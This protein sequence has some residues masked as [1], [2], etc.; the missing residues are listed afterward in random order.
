MRKYIGLCGLFLLLTL[1][2]L[3]QDYPKAE[4]FGG[5]SY[6]RSGGANFNGGSGSVA[7]N[8][9]PWL[10]LLGDIGVYHN[11]QV[12]STNF[13]TYLFGPR[14]SYRKSSKITPYAQFVL[15]G[16]HVSSSFAGFSASANAFALSMGGGLEAGISPR[17][18]VRLVQAEYL[19]T[20]NSGGTGNSARI[21]AG[22][23]FRWRGK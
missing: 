23:V 7:Y 21:S 14:L 22:L 9:N 4:I 6:L 18:A 15:G 11:G 19:L 1:P 17:F 8:P 12:G 2:A 10:G 16:A 13:V 20:K 5:Y 3:A